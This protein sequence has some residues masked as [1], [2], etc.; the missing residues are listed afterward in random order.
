[1]TSDQLKVIIAAKII[2]NEPQSAQLTLQRSPERGWHVAE[3]GRFL[4]NYYNNGE[5]PNNWKRVEKRT[6]QQSPG[7]RSV[8]REFERTG[9][10]LREIVA[11]T[12]IRDLPDRVRVISRE[13]EPDQFI[14]VREAQP[15]TPKIEARPTTPLIE[16]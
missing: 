8:I 13:G 4:G 11:R 6:S 16:L 9:A 1:M 15:E 5:L 2:T 7:D 14:W 12:I 3:D 10:P